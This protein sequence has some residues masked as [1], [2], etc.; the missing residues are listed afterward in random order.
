MS[1]YKYKELK[2]YK[3]CIITKTWITDTKIV[4][5]AVEE[6]TDALIGGADTLAELKKIVD[7]VMG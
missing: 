3:G 7:R 1:E 4:Y 6:E 2:P 5:D